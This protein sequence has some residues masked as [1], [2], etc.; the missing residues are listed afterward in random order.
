MSLATCLIWLASSLNIAIYLFIH[1][2]FVF[3][4]LQIFV[5]VD[6]QRVT[7][8][9]EVDPSLIE[10][11]KEEFIRLLSIFPHFYKGVS[12]NCNL[13]LFI[14]H[15]FMIKNSRDLLS[16]AYLNSNRVSLYF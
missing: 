6:E 1:F 7:L 2:L 12:N 13:K 8:K 5:L 10:K 4:A 16:L 9:A 11:N 3:V 14:N 15:T